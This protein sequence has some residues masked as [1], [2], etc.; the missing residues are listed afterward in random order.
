MDDKKI[1]TAFQILAQTDRLHNSRTGFGGANDKTRYN[2]LFRE[3][4][5]YD[6]YEQMFASSALARRIIELEP[7]FA[8]KN[9]FSFIFDDVEIVKY[10]EQEWKRLQVYDRIHE[11]QVWARLYGGSGI[12]ILAKDGKYPDEYLDIKTRPS[13]LKLHVFDR[14]WLSNTG[15]INSDFT[16]YNYGE[17]LRYYLSTDTGNFLKI[18]SSR[19]VKFIGNNLPRQLYIES[20]YWG[21]SILEPL[22]NIIAEYVSGYTG[23]ANLITDFRQ[24]V[25]KINNLEELIGSGEENYVQKRA[26]TIDLLRSILNAVVLGEGEEFTMHQNPVSGLSDL[27]RLLTTRLTTETGIPHTLIFGESPSG[28]GAT[29]E[30]EKQDYY[31]QI[32]S[33]QESYYEPRLRQLT[34]LILAQKGIYGLDYILKPLPIGSEDTKTKAEVRKL[35]AE[36]DQIM[37][38][39]GVVT[40]EEVRRIRLTEDGMVKDIIVEHEEEHNFSENDIS[41]YEK[42]LRNVK[43]KG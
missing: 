38:Q 5:S 3:R 30:S 4:R 13:I 41:E 17:P 32:H 31:N 33:L 24:T 18:D 26:E 6:A 36:A 23:V 15:T 22:Y 11:A 19:L 35:N 16:D 2:F 12:F 39:N 8:L 1:S 20:D 10:V 27:V 34:D 40:P 9:G 25:Y 29:G 21:Q 43:E 37:I 42:V 14:R 7:G 28:L